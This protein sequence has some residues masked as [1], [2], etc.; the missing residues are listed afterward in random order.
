MV[1][2]ALIQ[3]YDQNNLFGT[4]LKGSFSINCYKVG[5]V[6]LMVIVSMRPHADI[7]RDDHRETHPTLATFSSNKIHWSIFIEDT[8]IKKF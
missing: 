2:T 3:D 7:G 4:I 8:E 1:T 6:Y 5:Y